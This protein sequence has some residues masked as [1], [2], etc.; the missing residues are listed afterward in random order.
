MAP[1]VKKPGK[2]ATE[3]DWAEY[4]RQKKEKN[5]SVQFVLMTQERRQ[6]LNQTAPAPCAAISRWPIAHSRPCL[7][8]WVGGFAIRLRRRYGVIKQKKSPTGVGDV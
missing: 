2:K 5:L 4:R 1:L 7:W 3:A 8:G 6:R